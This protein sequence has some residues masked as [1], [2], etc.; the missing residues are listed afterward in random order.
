MQIEKV[1]IESQDATRD[2][3]KLISRK[4]LNFIND[5]DVESLEPR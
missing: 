5:I 4:N 1:V 3:I 2:V